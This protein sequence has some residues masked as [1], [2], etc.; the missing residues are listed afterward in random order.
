MLIPTFQIL[1]VLHSNMQ[2]ATGTLPGENYINFF[3]YLSFS[4]MVRITN[5]AVHVGPE[6][7]NTGIELAYKLQH[8]FYRIYKTRK[9]YEDLHNSYS[10]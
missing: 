3:F 8:S 4:C 9:E 1:G 7:H 2:P 10:S 6:R 5:H